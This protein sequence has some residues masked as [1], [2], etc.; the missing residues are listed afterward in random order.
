MCVSPGHIL[1]YV[2]TRMGICVR[3][4]ACGCVCVRV[5]AGAVVCVHVCVCMCVRVLWVVCERK[6]EST[7]I[8]F[9]AVEGQIFSVLRDESK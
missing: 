3:A 5:R 6:I 8:I 2:C 4:C 9:V 7:P 1:T